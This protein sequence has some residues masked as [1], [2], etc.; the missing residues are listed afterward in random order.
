M[1]SYYVSVVHSKVFE[2]TIQIPLAVIY[3]LVVFEW[4]FKGTNKE[5]VSL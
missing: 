3:Y 4:Y 2:N 5:H 1:I